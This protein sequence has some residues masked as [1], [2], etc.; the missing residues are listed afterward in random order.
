MIREIQGYPVLDGFRGQPPVDIDALADCL[1]SVA[2][3]AKENSKIT[4]IDLNPVFAYPQAI[5]IADA[6]IIM[7]EG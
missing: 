6:R 5:L 1:L 7:E 3:I 2:E 4:E